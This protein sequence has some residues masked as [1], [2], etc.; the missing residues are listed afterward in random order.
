MA[1]IHK[2]KGN[3]LEDF[4]PGHVF[5]HKVGKTITEG[6]RGV[7][8]VQTTGRNQHGEASAI[9]RSVRTSASFQRFCTDTSTSEKTISS[10][11]STSSIWNGKSP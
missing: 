6:D 4:R 1:V 3:F 11:K 2:K 5:Q 8:H 7:V 9:S 10:K